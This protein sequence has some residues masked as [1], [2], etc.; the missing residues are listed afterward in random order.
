MQLAPATIPA[1]SQGSPARSASPQTGASPP[2]DSKLGSSNRR[3]AVRD[4]H[5]P[6][7]LSVRDEEPSQVP[8]S[9]VTG[10]FV[11]H[12]LPPHPPL[13]RIETRGGA[14]IPVTEGL[15]SPLCAM[16]LRGM[17]CASSL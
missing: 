4:S 17:E 3:D 7:A 9:L 15:G 5:T 1:A 8:S 12:D 6:D 14:M 11:C 10:A 13:R 2:A 16:A